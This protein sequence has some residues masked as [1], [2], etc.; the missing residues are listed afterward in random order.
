MNGNGKMAIPPSV[1]G[2][3]GSYSSPFNTLMGGV[4]GAKSFGLAMFPFTPVPFSGP[5]SMYAWA[6]LLIYG[7]IAG[8]TFQKM[9]TVSYIAMGAAGVSVMTSLSSWGK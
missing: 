1:P 4:T 2:V 3:D 5:D 7:T 6:R 8:L 9:R